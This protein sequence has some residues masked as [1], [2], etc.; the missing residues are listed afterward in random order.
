MCTSFLLFFAVTWELCRDLWYGPGR[1]DELAPWT[2]ELWIEL[3]DHLQ[4]TRNR[5]ENT[6]RE[7]KTPHPILSCNFITFKNERYHMWSTRRQVTYHVFV[8]F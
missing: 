5:E 3:C 7:G 1:A 6:A 2:L 8:R 4:G